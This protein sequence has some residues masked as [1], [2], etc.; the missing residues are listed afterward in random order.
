MGLPREELLKGGF[1]QAEDWSYRWCRGSSGLVQETMDILF[2][3]I[4][5]EKFGIVNCCCLARGGESTFNQREGTDRPR[6]TAREAECW[7]NL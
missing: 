2:Q 5:L 7:D 6:T 3:M 1:Q 4:C